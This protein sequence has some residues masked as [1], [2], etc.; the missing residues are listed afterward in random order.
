M[1]IKQEIRNLYET[2]A[3][4][5]LGE[6]QRLARK[7]LAEHHCLDE[8]VMAMGMAIFTLKDKDV[9]DAN[10]H[11]HERAYFKPLEDLLNEWDEVLKLTGEP[12][13]FRATGPKIT[14][15]G[16][17]DQECPYCHKNYNECRCEIQV[18]MPPSRV[19]R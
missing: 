14:E 10:L 3:E 8:F 11:L 1:G 12:M 18:Q 5:A 17:T 4:L 16:A 13:R 7:I 19:R 9:R 6:V 2:A 15:W